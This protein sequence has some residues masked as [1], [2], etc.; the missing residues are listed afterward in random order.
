MDMLPILIFALKD[1]S[2]S[3]EN[4]SFSN[5]WIRP[6]NIHYVHKNGDV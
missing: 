1:S 3:Y 6:K 4:S 2:K 5:D